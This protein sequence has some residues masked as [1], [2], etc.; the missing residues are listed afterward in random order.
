M[1][2]SQREKANLQ[3]Q[4]VS[5]TNPSEHIPTAPQ[6]GVI[7]TTNYPNLSEDVPPSYAQSQQQPFVN[8]PL[9]YPHQNQQFS[10]QPPL[11]QQQPFNHQQFPQPQV[12][13]QPYSQAPIQQINVLQMHRKYI[14]VN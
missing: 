13:P 9:P 8:Q 4:Y 5:S 3:Q 14:G 1:D 2:S 12:Y 6:D 11:N 7:P 10:Q